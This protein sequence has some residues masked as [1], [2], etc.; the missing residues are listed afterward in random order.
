MSRDWDDK[1]GPLQGPSPVDELERR[2]RAVLERLDPD[3]AAVMEVQGRREL[4][5]RAAARQHHADVRDAS[6]A[7]ASAYF[8]KSGPAEA[9]AARQ[10]IDRARAQL[11]AHP[12]RWEGREHMSE[13]E[14]A[15]WHAQAWPEHLEV[16]QQREHLDDYV[17]E[18]TNDR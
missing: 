2:V 6:H 4:D 8:E 11:A 9:Q 17:Q 14:Q 15:A 3:T 5:R 1:E 16:P 10:R 7:V 13:D 12:T 18:H